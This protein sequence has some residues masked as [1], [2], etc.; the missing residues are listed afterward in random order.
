MYVP[1]LPEGLEVLSIEVFSE[2]NYKYRITGKETNGEIR[3]YADFSTEALEKSQEYVLN[4]KKLSFDSGSKKINVFY[5]N[6]T[7]NHIEEVEFCV[8]VNVDGII[9]CYSDRADQMPS[10]D[11]FLSFDLVKYIPE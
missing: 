5:R 11:W 7:E 6:Y 4:W 10:D 2:N 3:G 8:F 9:Y 1:V